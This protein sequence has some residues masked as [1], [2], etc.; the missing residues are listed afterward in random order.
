MHF[1]DEAWRGVKRETICVKST[2]DGREIAK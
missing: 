1:A 2:I